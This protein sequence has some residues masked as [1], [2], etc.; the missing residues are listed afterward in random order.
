MTV[1]YDSAPS[2]QRQRLGAT[3]SVDLFEASYSPY[4][5]LEFQPLSWMRFV[6]GIRADVYQFDVRESLSRLP[7]A[8]RGRNQ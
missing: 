8:A 1:R 6:G 5:K 2:S 7:R 4:L 3:T